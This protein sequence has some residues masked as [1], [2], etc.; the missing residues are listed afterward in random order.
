MVILKKFFTVKHMI[1]YFQKT[2]LFGKFAFYGCWCFPD[3]PED[4][5][6]G[7]GEPVDEIDRNCKKSAFE[8]L[9]KLNF[10]F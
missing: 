4:I 3:G 5:D 8:N 1:M 7:Y 2:P 6:K 9:I 10:L